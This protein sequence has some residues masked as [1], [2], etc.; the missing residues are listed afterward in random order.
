MFHNQSIFDASTI[1]VMDDEPRIL[2]VTLA[3]ALAFS[4]KYKIRD[5]IDR[6]NEELADYGR[7]FTIAVKTTA[8][9]GRPGKAYY[10]NEGQ[11]LAICALSRTPAAAQVRKALIELFMAYR[12]GEL[13]T[14]HV[15][16]HYRRQPHPRALPPADNHE[17]L[18]AFFRAFRNEPEALADW[19]ELQLKMVDGLRNQILGRR[20]L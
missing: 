14:V 1:V 20:S 10:L 9:G 7:V 18:T 6:N 4:S 12:R 11:A 8:S 5:I 13:K 3:S 19:A 16:E 15:R 2:D 17:R